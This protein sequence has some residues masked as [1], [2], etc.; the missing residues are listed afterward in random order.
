MAEAIVVEPGVELEIEPICV[1]TK[2]DTG[3]NCRESG[4]KS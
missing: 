3:G 4:S 1:D 2:L